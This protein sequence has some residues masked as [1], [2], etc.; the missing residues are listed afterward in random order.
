MGPRQVKKWKQA[1]VVLLA[2]YPTVL[3]LNELFGWL[4]PEDTPY[5]LAVLIGNI[6]GVAILSWI[7]MPRL[8]GWLDRW[9]RR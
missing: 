9:L 3:V 7:L 2:L 5:L 1:A 8:T 4:L 6:A